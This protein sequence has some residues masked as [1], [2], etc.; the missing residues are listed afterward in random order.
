MFT[1]KIHL[2]FPIKVR[3][4]RTEDKIYPKRLYYDMKLQLFIL[5][6]N[7]QGIK[8]TLYLMIER[9]I[10]FCFLGKRFLSIFIASRSYYNCKIM[11]RQFNYKEICYKY[12]RWNF[13]S[14]STKS[15]KSNRIKKKTPI[16]KTVES[17]LQ[18]R[19]MNRSIHL[20]IYSLLFLLA[21][22]I[23]NTSA[24]CIPS[25]NCDCD[26]KNIVGCN[27]T[28]IALAG[29]TC[30]KEFS[31]ALQDHIYQVSDHG[32]F[33]HFGNCINGCNVHNPSS[34]CNK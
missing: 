17:R 16:K 12:G 27:A 13:F 9:C 6:E 31:C 15:T 34:F 8:L 4:I 20:F 22:L 18:K 10:N 28:G 1:D 14:K 29:T 32:T 19:K 3:K 23:S 5:F 11:K 21:L 7:K 33:C 24:Q 30:G 25:S 26:P 2:Y